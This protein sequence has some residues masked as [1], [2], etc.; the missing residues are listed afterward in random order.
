[1]QRFVRTLVI[2]N[3]NY[4]QDKNENPKGATRSAGLAFL[5]Q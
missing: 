1:M 4:V 3:T 2:G 5:A